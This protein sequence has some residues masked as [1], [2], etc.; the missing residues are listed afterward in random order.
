[1]EHVTTKHGSGCLPGEIICVNPL[2][3]CVKILE[4]G[5][6]ILLFSPVT[7]VSGISHRFP[8]QSLYLAGCAISA[9]FLCFIFFALLN[10]LMPAGHRYNPL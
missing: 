4:K 5:V 2:F 8:A 1:V 3:I 7:V 6:I 10:R 9:C